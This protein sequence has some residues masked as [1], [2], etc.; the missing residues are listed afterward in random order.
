L[1]KSDNNVFK[2]INKSTSSDLDPSLI[3]QFEQLQKHFSA[4]RRMG[5]D[6]K[7]LEEEDRVLLEAVTKL[8]LSRINELAESKDGSRSELVDLLIR[9]NTLL[10]D[11]SNTISD[12]YFEGRIDPQQLVNTSWED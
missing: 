10:S 4:V 3:F 7:G 8:K 12:R 2:R 1:L 6:T 5:S 11:F 9:L